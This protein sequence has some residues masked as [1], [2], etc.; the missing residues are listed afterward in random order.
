MRENEKRAVVLSQKSTTAFF[1]YVLTIK[2][3]KSVHYFQKHVNALRKGEDY[4]EK[5]N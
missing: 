4:E 5:I 3:E 2:R 1:K